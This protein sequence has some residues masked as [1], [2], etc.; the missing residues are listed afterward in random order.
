V[1][2][3]LVGALISAGPP[4][5]LVP[6]FTM[7][8]PGQVICRLI[9]VPTADQPRLQAWGNRAMSLSA[10][11]AEEVRSAMNEFAGY[12][13]DL[14]AARRAQPGD[15]LLTTLITA[16]DEGDA[17]T[18]G[19]LVSLVRD[20]IVGGN[21]TTMTALGNS[22]VALLD[23][24]GRGGWLRLT[25]Q[26]DLAA[27]AVEE[28]LRR[29]PLGEGITEAG[30]I[31]RTLE[32]VELGGVTLPAGSLVAAGTVCAN[33]DPAVYPEPDGLDIT[34]RPATPI[35]TFGAGPHNCLGAWLARMELELGL[36][37]LATRL[38]DLRLDVPVDQVPFT[39]G[40]MTRGPAALPVTWSQPRDGGTA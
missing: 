23:D 16:R 26:P 8:L 27:T 37:H 12:V 24:N 38:P 22:L 14:V 7:A 3:D 17:L 20:L 9:G 5:D 13:L 34:R 4:A 35:M 28:L 19:E 11:P 18:D 1:I 39:S 30:L 32:D 40:L 25:A 15:D 10:F 31:R 36:R 29:V 6:T 2:D 33:L 21:E